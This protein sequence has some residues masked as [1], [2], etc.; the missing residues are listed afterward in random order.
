MP[1]LKIKNQKIKHLVVSQNKK[2]SEA[3]IQSSCVIRMHNEYPET[4][5]C[6]F[7][8]TNNSEH[9]VRGLQRKALGMV[10]GV[11]DTLFFWKNQLYCFEFKTEVGRQSPAQKKWA[12]TIKKQG[13]IYYVVR[14][15]E[16]FFEIVRVI[17]GC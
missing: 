11:S 17:L 13:A 16:Q 2:L 7:A 12:E 4:R 5:G 1:S 14:S 9:A 15:E 3:Q 6:F 8:V 10:P